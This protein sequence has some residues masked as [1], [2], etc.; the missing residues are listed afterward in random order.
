VI[1]Q[2][3]FETQSACSKLVPKSEELGVFERGT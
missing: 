3:V 2:A 1:W